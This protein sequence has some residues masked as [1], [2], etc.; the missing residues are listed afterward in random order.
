MF[1]R[2]FLFAHN[3]G[4]D[5]NLSLQLT[6]KTLFDYVLSQKLRFTDNSKSFMLQ[7]GK[8]IMI[9][10]RMPKVAVECGLFQIKLKS[11]KHYGRLKW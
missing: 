1:E 9:Q 2:F 7:L 4:T 6:H 3:Q 10:F 8:F 5:R 11:L